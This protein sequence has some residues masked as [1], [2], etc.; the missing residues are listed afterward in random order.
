MFYVPLASDL[1]KERRKE[2]QMSA[3]DKEYALNVYRHQDRWVTLSA[4]CVAWMYE[5]I[6]E[7]KQ[8]ALPEVEGELI[9]EPFFLVAATG[10]GKTLLVPPLIQAINMVNAGSCGLEKLPLEVGPR[11]W[12]VEPKIVIAQS[13]TAEMNRNWLK[14]LPGFPIKQEPFPLFG[15]K[16]KVDHVNV[17]APIMFITTG[18][19]SIYARNGVFRPG[20]DFVLIDEAH[21]TLETDEALELGVGICRSRWVG[22]SYMSASVDSTDIPARLGVKVIKAGS[23]RFPIWKHNLGQPIEQCLTELVEGT[24]VTPDLDGEFFPDASD[25]TWRPVRQAVLQTGRAKGMLIVVN[26]Y[27][28]DDSD[29]KRLERQLKQAPFASKIS[30]R[31]LAGEVLR[32]AEKRRAYES[33]LK[34]WKEEKTRYVLIATSVVEMGVTLPDLDFVVTMDSS[35][36][37]TENG[38]RMGLLGTNALIQRIGRVGRE[39]PG[40]A[41][42]SKE[43]GAP[44]ALL[45]DEDLNASGALQPEPISWPTERGDLEWLAYYSFQQ[46][47]DELDLLKRLKELDLPSKV[48]TRWKADELEK[49]RQAFI[50]AGLAEG[51]SLTDKGIEIEGWLGFQSLRQLHLLKLL[52]C[53]YDSR[54]FCAEL[55]RAMAETEVEGLRS[56]ELNDRS[57]EEDALRQIP[58]VFSAGVRRLENSSSGWY[59]SQGSWERFEEALL[60]LDVGRDHVDDVLKR[61]MRLLEEAVIHIEQEFKRD[62]NGE[63]R[64][65][66]DRFWREL[67]YFQSLLRQILA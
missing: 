21:V 52:V 25:E 37:E 64:S 33:D 46:E 10:L 18:M 35:I 8:L 24:L 27:S 19:F 7:E 6:A 9:E 43:R 17:D 26:S 62:R 20:K 4:S 16:T 58:M 32:D 22:L 13:L 1:S 57:D 65:F 14:F 15:C 47:W 12:V 51:N 28:A 11:V 5:S 41:Y 63:S 39:R 48:A 45:D 23:Q 50:Q 3:R 30:V 34:R 66:Q 60:G 61:T 67:R 36:E 29:A 53:S 44:Y 54:G 56:E 31:T 2:G 40:I 38:V 59:S 55:L 42:I 49:V